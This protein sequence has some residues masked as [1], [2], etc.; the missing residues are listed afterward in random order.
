MLWNEVQKPNIDGRTGQLY[1]YTVGF[2]PFL[3]FLTD[4]AFSLLSRVASICY[5]MASS[6]LV[7]FPICGQTVLLLQSAEQESNIHLLTQILRDRS[8]SRATKK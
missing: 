8:S 4:Q 2:F 6:L 7:R 5:L 3:L 1:S